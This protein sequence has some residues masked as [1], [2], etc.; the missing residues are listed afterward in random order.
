[1]FAQPSTQIT[2]IEHEAIEYDAPP[3]LAAWDVLSGSDELDR[4]ALWVHLRDQWLAIQESDATRAS[5]KT[6]SIQWL[7]WLAS[8]TVYP[9]DATSAH[10][11]GWQAWLTDSGKGPST[12]NQRLSAVSSWYQFV[13]NEV[14]MVDGIERSA[15]N[16]ASGNTRA[17]P[18]KVGNIKRPKVTQYGKAAPLHTQTVQKLIAYLKAHGDTLTGSRNYA[19]VF[20]HLLTA[21]R[22]SEIVRLRW[23]DIRPNREHEGQYI[24]DWKGKGDKE[25]KKAF[26]APVYALIV[27][28]LKIAGRY[29]PGHEDHIQDDDFIFVPLVTHGLKNL[30]NATPNNP[31]PGTGTPSMG[32]AG[33]GSEENTPHLSP[34]SAQRILQTSLRSAGIENWANYRVHDLRHTFAHAHYKENHDLESLRDILNHESIATTGIY[35]RNMQEPV[36]DYTQGVMR[37][38]GLI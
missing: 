30:R 35:I 24:F 33:W 27:A 10:V 23:K 19:L 34:K 11:R 2:V 7:R 22:G 1:M 38:M 17:N 20:S 13:I 28:H 6:G 25:K 37:Q 29:L 14:H 18:F 8:Q 31:S 32:E 16:D 5:Y 36:D 3:L 12:V 4:L 21:S 15:F 26:P 9:W